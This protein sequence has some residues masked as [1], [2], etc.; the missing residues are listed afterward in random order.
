MVKNPNRDKE[1]LHRVSTV[2]NRAKI[3][4]H[5]S[6]VRL[7]MP[8]ELKSPKLIYQYKGT[9]SLGRNA[10]RADAEI[11]PTDHPIGYL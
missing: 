6:S 11:L 1:N 2:S 9:R 3:G 5:L 4:K 7:T 8:H 10:R